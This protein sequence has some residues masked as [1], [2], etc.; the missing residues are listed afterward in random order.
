MDDLE[1]AIGTRGLGAEKDGCCLTLQASTKCH[2]EKAIL[3]R[4]NAEEF[5]LYFEAGAPQS[6]AKPFQYL[7]VPKEIAAN[8]RRWV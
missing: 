4:Q 3:K 1:V 5:A 8:C 7:I 2:G 6:P